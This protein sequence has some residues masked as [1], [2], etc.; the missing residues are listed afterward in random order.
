MEIRA[1]EI[2]AVKIRAVEMRA[3]GMRAIGMR[4]I[5]VRAVEMD[6][7]GKVPM[8]VHLRNDRAS[9]AIDA[10]EA[11]GAPE[12]IG[13]PEPETRLPTPRPQRPTPPSSIL[14]SRS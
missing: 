7:A 2:Q 3:V 4:T 14:C 9:E 8:V 10:F 5:E 1:T 6:P 12:A 13:I 11:N